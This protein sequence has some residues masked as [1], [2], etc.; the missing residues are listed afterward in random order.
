MIVVRRRRSGSYGA[1]GAIVAVMAATRR[2]TGAKGYDE[3]DGDCGA[4]RVIVRIAPE[5]GHGLVQRVIP[6]PPKVPT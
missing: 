6:T 5:V 1:S 3:E 2:Y 4:D